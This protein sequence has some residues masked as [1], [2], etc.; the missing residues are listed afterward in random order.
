MQSFNAFYSALK[1]CLISDR[2]PILQ[3]MRRA[4]SLQRQQK[5]IEKL[6][7]EIEKALQLSQEKAQARLARLPRPHFDLSLPVNEKRE[8]IQ[9]AISRHQVVIICGETGSGK[10]TQIPKI[11]LELGRGVCGK[12]GHT[13][14]R[15]LATRAV[16]SRLAQELGA[17][18]LVGYKVRFTENS[19]PHNLIKVMTDGILLAETQSDRFLSE[20]DTIIIDEAH[21]RSLN[22]DFLLG[23]LKTLL[24]KRQDLKLIITSATIDAERFAAHF[25]QAPVI[26]VSGRT[27]PVDIH[28]RPLISQDEDGREVEM[29]EAI[30]DA[31]DELWR[32]GPGDILVFLPG[33]REIRD[34]ADQ[35]RRHIKQAE[36]LPLFARLSHEDQQRI[37]HRSG[38]R[39]IVLSTNVA[40]TSLTVPGIRYV[41]DSGLVRINRYSPRAKIEQLQVEKTSQASARQ[42]AGRCGRVSA[43]VCIRLFDEADFLARPAFTDPEILRSSLAAVIL[44]MQSLRMQNIEDFPFI[45]HPSNRQI[46]DGYQQLHELGAIDQHKAL[47]PVGQALAHLPV[48]PRIGRMLLAANEM[49]CLTEILQI[50]S[51]LSI[52]DPRERPTDAR[53]AADRAHQRFNDEK[54]DFLSYLNIWHFFNEALRDKTSNRQLINLCHEHFLSYLRLREWRDLHGQLKEIAQEMGWRLNETPADYAA[55]H[56]ALLTGLLSQIGMKQPEADQYLGARD[57]KFHIFPGSGLKK[58]RPKWI[59]AALLMETSRLYA[60]CVASIDPAW[61]ERIAAHLVKHHYYDPHWED[62]GAQIVAS[63]RITLFGLP[64]VNQRRVHYGSI[65]PTEARRIFIEEA[66]VR[67]RLRT[68]AGFFKHNHALISEVEELEHKARR[69]DVLVDEHLLFTFYDEKIPADVVNG[70]SFEAWFKK[71]AEP[72]RQKLFLDKTF[73]MQHAATHITEMQFPET[74][75]VDGITLPLCYHFEPGHI[76]DGVT[77]SL[78]LYLLNQI[79][80]EPF[81]WL[82][83]G[84]LREKLNWLIK[85]LPKPLRRAC[86]PI[87]DF[88]TRLL[89]KLDT[90]DQQAALLPQLVAYLNRD[91][92]LT[93]SAANF[94]IAD[95]P[96]HLVMNF[97]I[98][99]EGGHSLA[100]GRD[101]YQLQQQ[102]GEAAQMTFRDHADFERTDIRSWDFGDLPEALTFSH[103]SQ[104]LTG[105]PAL[106]DEGEACALRL[107]DTAH[108]AQAATRRGVI[109]LIQFDLKEHMKQLAKVSP[110]LTQIALQLR[111][112]MS[113]EQLQ[114]DLIQAICDR[115]FIG[116]DPLPRTEKAYQTQRERA[117]ARQPAV[118]DAMMQT[119]TNVAQ[120]YHTLRTLLQQPHRLQKPLQTQLQHL[121]YPGFLGQTPYAQLA[122]L[123]RYLQA[124]KV[125][126]EKY[127]DNPARDSKHAEEITRLW[128]RW[129]QTCKAWQETGRDITPLLPFRWL[130]EE[131][132]V[133][134][135]AQALRTPMPVSVKR[136]E[137]SWADS[138]QAAGTP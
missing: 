91:T 69:Q 92:G 22:I 132:R 108:E 131:L 77:V 133:S 4:E 99:D 5:P 121:V 134:L 110:Q 128:T 17:T 29:E 49:R 32:K 113:A 45:D 21:E 14:P 98:V 54:S 9:T 56:Q 60:Y 127:P 119:L 25:D 71:T 59:V 2:Y 106:V 26:E 24:P 30:V 118:R 114:Q 63:E 20:Y 53:E 101:L 46:T 47:T 16:A 138:I 8:I 68:R 125:R 120:H 93:L 6:L 124:I 72:E 65:D 67:Q 100:T 94:A 55:I 35:L 57:I 64:I 112:A 105:Y 115:A 89:E 33:E 109:R 70:Q 27:Y 122:H 85:S 38:G 13:Q 103:G 84:L 18:D 79:S 66:L 95:L 7:A 61:L 34:T 48:D 126:W 19:A 52:Q 130:L 102:L 58:S 51:A 90:F 3:K 62:K 86:V 78:P 104:T 44:R 81:E 111:P 31:V 82:V 76:M 75:M 42:R 117:R 73:L 10:T 88:V 23:Y 50:A 41:I 136:L 129:E 36:I 15:R 39:R 116:E 74:L 83:P 80:R 135:F 137:K 107:M 37:F 96:A 97:D 40:E 87:P 12:I 123:P 11:C 1:Q 28:Y 43:G